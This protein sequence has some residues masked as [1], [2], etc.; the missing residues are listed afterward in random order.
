M[1][2]SE[3]K[4]GEYSLV[5]ANKGRMLPVLLTRE[6]HETLQI[7]IQALP[8]DKI[9]VMDTYTQFYGRGKRAKKVSNDKNTLPTSNL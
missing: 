7:L 6:Q 4:D 2:I 9:R 3:A 5:Y 1:S 8:G